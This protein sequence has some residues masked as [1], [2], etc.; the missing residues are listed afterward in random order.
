MLATGDQSKLINLKNKPL[1]NL[2][3]LK[4]IES[5]IN[6]HRQKHIEMHKSAS[7]NF[8]INVNSDKQEVNRS[9]TF[10]IN[11]INS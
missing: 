11:Y 2:S 1:L 5:F 6:A 10:I 7:S 8:N 9:L 4:E 3:M